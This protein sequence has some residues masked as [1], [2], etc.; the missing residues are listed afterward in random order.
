MSWAFADWMAFL[1]AFLVRDLC[2]CFLWCFSSPLMADEARDTSEEVADMLEHGHVDAEQRVLSLDSS[3][4]W[5]SR[6][7]PNWKVMV[8]WLARSRLLEAQCLHD[9]G[10]PSPAGAGWR[11]CQTPPRTIVRNCA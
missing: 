2:L 7:S 9:I 10:L 1:T 11:R 3:G 4:I 8:G 5:A 6:D